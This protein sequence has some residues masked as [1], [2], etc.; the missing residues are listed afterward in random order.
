MHMLVVTA[1]PGV[2]EVD[3][4]LAGRNFAF[5]NRFAAQT[6]GGPF[7]FLPEP[8]PNQMTGGLSQGTSTYSFRCGRPVKPARRM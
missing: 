2:L 8:P 6:C 4:S 7:T 5:A 3:D 1:N